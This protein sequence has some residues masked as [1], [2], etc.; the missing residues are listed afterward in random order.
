MKEKAITAV[1]VVAIIVAIVQHTSLAVLPAAD[2]EF[3]TGLAV[4]FTFA[5]IITWWS[6]RA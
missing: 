5:A 3:I 2:T 1:A 4:G 6:G